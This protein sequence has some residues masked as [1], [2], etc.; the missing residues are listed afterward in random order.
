MSG[1]MYKVFC[2]NCSW[3]IYTDDDSVLWFKHRYCPECL[4]CTDAIKVEIIKE[5]KENKI[6]K[7]EKGE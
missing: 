1:M 4:G 7:K 6:S 2:V 3:H 5:E